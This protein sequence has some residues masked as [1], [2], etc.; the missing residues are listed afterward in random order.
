M[1]E[2]LTLKFDPNTIEHLGISLYSKLPSVLSELVSN[3]WDAD[4]DKVYITFYD[5]EGSK[6]IV[7]E[8]DGTGMSFDE[9]N[10]KFLLIGRNRRKENS[11]SKTA[12]D[13][14]VIGKKGLGKLSV[15]GICDI[16]E[17]KSVKGGILNHFKMNLED[18]KNSNTG[19]YNPELLVSKNTSTTQKNGT[20]L[21]LKSIRRKSGF[22]LSDIAV[23]LSKKFMIFD[24]LKLTMFLNE[25]NETIVTNEMKFNSFEEQFRW[26]FPNSLD[27]VYRYK[28]QV[29]GFILTTLTPIKDTDMSGIYLVSRGKI[30]NTAS[31]YGLRD[32]DQFHSYVTG[33]LDVDF[34][35]EFDEDVIST[36]RH[37]LNWENDQTKELQAFLQ[38]VIKK[39]GNEWKRKRSE[40]KREDIKKETSLDIAEW[41]QTLPTFEREL[42]DKIFNP[43]LSNPRIEADKSS[44]IIKNVMDKFDNRT[45][46]EYAEKIAEISS[47]EQLPEF[48]KLIEDWKAIEARQF[49]D[50]S[51]S[52]VEVIKQFEEY[53]RT[54]TREVPTLHNF[55]KK[56][57]WLL[58]PRI[59]EFKDE[60][61]YSLLL[62]E[63]FP[64]EKLSET[65]RR[66]DFLCSNALG[67]IL[68]VIEI[69]RS[70]FEV[71]ENALEQAYDYQ[72]FLKEK[73]STQSG[74]SKVVCFVVGGSKANSRKFRDKE[75]TYMKS[76]EV[77]V[78]TYIELLEQSKEYHK[79]FIETYNQYSK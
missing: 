3:S 57:S 34:I 63:H 42:S 72:S 78:K 30:V 67:E 44:E 22:N 1:S 62:K 36:D 23:S 53:L 52:R 38:N 77:F 39:I 8:D 60:V 46:K 33:Y 74:F 47:E 65:N 66:I 37:S 76:G 16:I 21:Y 2:N 68:Y 14:F 61:Y 71:D 35:D 11:D 79:E 29:K 25:A 19:T 6:E 43:I 4:A 58:D 73:Y 26:N 12:K 5:R 75:Q 64:D 59:L 13:R 10:E 48:L 24:V 31:F 55:L 27:E 54:D 56:F 7:Y 32:N 18:I 45:F 51:I 49:R 40:A 70:S 15:F 41:Q 28:D 69:K 17:V 50:I 20:T 9:L